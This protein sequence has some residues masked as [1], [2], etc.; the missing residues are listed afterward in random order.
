MLSFAIAK[1]L[2]L[3]PGTPIK[4]RWSSQELL[5]SPPP[6]RR[7]PSLGLRSIARFSSAAN[8][9]SVTGYLTYTFT[10][11]LHQDVFTLFRASYQNLH[12]NRREE[13]IHF[14][15]LCSLG[16]FFFFS[17]RAV[18]LLWKGTAGACNQ[19]KSLLNQPANSQFMDPVPLQSPQTPSMEADTRLAVEL[20]L[21]ATFPSGVCQAAPMKTEDCT[22]GSV[23]SVGSTSILQMRTDTVCSVLHKLGVIRGFLAKLDKS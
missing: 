22:L 15:F 4:R 1:N 19:L 8:F 3:T 21:A 16:F 20:W 14:I 12:W 9:N 10:S 2:V 23:V 5:L 6:A 11:P 13:G 7:L 18:Y 17:F